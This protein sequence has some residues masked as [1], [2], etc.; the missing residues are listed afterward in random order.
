L[1]FDSVRVSVHSLV[2]S[3]RHFVEYLTSLRWLVSRFGWLSLH[4]VEDIESVVMF[5]RHSVD[6][7]HPVVTDVDPVVAFF[8]PFRWFI[9]PVGFSGHPVVKDLDLFRFSIRPT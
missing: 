4:R 6:D 8:D 9:G 1:D 5:I 7:I 3:F 2:Q